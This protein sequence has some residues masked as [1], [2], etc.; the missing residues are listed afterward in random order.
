MSNITPFIAQLAITIRT[1]RKMSG[2]TQAQLANFAGVGK[3]II[4]DLEHGKST[5]QLNTLLKVLETLNIQLQI[6]S[7]LGTHY[8]QS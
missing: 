1:H 4:F 6:Q 8:A 3:T 2:L 7:P 5:V